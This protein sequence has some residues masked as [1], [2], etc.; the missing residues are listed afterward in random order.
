VLEDL[1]DLTHMNVVSRAIIRVVD[2]DTG[3]WLSSGC[4][5]LEGNLFTIPVLQGQLLSRGGALHSSAAFF[6]LLKV[7]YGLR[8]VREGT[9]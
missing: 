2:T 4:P 1:L 9:N 5:T 7:Y 3:I 8:S 6:G